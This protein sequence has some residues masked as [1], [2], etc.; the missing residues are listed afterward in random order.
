MRFPWLLFVMLWVGLP[1]A[2]AQ[3]TLVCD[4]AEQLFSQVRIQPP[5]IAPDLPNQYFVTAI[6]IGDYNPVVGVTLPPVEEQVL[7]AYC[8]AGDSNAMRYEAQLPTAGAVPPAT[9]SAQEVIV[10]RGQNMIDVGEFDGA[11]G[12]FLVV[13]EGRFDPDLNP[14]DDTFTVAITQNLIDAEL[15]LTAYLFALTEGYTPTLTLTAGETR[16]S[17]QPVDDPQTRLRSALGDSTTSVQATLP[18]TLTDVSLTVEA[19]EGAIYALVLH[20]GS[21]PVVPPQDTALV[22][23]TPDGALILRC[24][25]TEI[26]QNGIAFQMPPTGDYTITALN[27]G[28]YVP[29]IAI[30]DEDNAGTCY[31]ATPAARSYGVVLPSTQAAVS[32]LHAQGRTTEAQRTVV[33]GSQGNF[34]GEVVLVIEGGTLNETLPSATYGLTVSPGMATAGASITAY[35][36]AT[37]LEL[38]TVLTLVD[39]AGQ[40]VTDDGGQVIACDNAGISDGC[41]GETVLLRDALVNLADG[42]QL[43]GFELDSMLVIPPD[44]QTAREALQM[45]MRGGSNGLVGDYVLVWHVI[46]N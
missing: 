45:E 39:A 41:Y 21:V 43:A 9:S 10:D 15:P 30:V 11:G 19:V 12:E 29:V 26:F 28:A 38:D 27:S 40:P 17:A 7:P 36:L 46:T 20:L 33:V 4:S 14:D 24:G 13:L 8:N 25:G 18:R 16:L 44:A 42:A 35:A 32:E 37:V 31:S 3:D 5:E 23:E 34:P 6:G 2:A 1:P 22:T